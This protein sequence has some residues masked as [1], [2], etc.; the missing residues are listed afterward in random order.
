VISTR[1]FGRRTNNGPVTAT[2]V[3][4]NDPLPAGFT[5]I[6]ATPTQG[7]CSGTTTVS[8]TLGTLLSG[9]SATITLHGAL[10]T[11][12]PLSNTATVTANETDPVPANNTSTAA[13]I[14]VDEVPAVG[15]YGLMLL[16]LVLGVAGA[17]VVRN[18][19]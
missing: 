11:P 14:V 2:G 5:L 12:G 15:G 17:F 6:L 1:R 19:M 9:A 7:S 13:V 4:V 8:C 3:T 18:R 10:T 16:A